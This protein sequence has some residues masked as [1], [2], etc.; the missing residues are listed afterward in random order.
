ME[1]VFALH[2]EGV[3]SFDCALRTRLDFD[4]EDVKRM[5]KEMER[6]VDSSMKNNG[7]EGQH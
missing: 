4:D 6:K 7:R 5:K 1:N 2:S 3:F